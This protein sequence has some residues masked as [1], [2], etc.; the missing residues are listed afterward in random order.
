M[1]LLNGQ[2]IRPTVFPDRTSQVWQ[3]GDLLTPNI[4]VTWHFE[5]EAELF[6]LAQLK[7]LIDKTVHSGPDR[8]I[9]TLKIPYLPY[10]R[11][12]KD[13]SDES[14]FALEVFADYLNQQHW[15][16]ITTFDVHSD[17]A[18]NKIKN[19][20][21]I[22]PDLYFASQFDYVVFPDKG[23]E[24]RYGSRIHRPKLV[25][26]KQRDQK[27]GHISSY[28][29]SGSTEETILTKADTILVIDDLCDG[30][31]TFNILAKSLKEWGAGNKITLYVSHGLFSKGVIELFQNYEKIITTNTC[32]SH[33][34]RTPD[35]LDIAAKQSHSWFKMRSH[36][37][38]GS[39]II[40][41]SI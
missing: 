17:V 19:L 37:T 35:G 3:L 22:A 8:R 9:A 33:I 32:F 27:T 24:A 31:A 25:G 16:Q 1:I 26:L 11:Q 12:D 34:M 15:D 40:L 29:L 38:G 30:G 4:T 6:H 20:L 41:P 21:N 7:R 18:S 10:A 5:Q 28:A 36:I 13:V 2:E 23:A 14:T 39:M